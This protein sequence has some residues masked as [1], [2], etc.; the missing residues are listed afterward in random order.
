MSDR[1]TCG[2]CIFVRTDVLTG[3]ALCVRHPPAHTMP[4]AAASSRW[5][6]VHSDEWCGEHRRPPGRPKSASPKG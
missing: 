4:G 2:S 1:P 5:P 6:L 3:Q